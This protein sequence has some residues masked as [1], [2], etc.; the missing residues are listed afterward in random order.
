MLQGITETIQTA[1]IFLE[2]ASFWNAEA[3]GPESHIGILTTQEG[4]LARLPPSKTS[5]GEGEYVT[6]LLEPS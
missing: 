3:R 1:S 5:T 6:R 4:I 2:E